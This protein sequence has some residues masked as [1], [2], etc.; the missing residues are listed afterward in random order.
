MEGFKS[1][2]KKKEADF[3]VKNCTTCNSCWEV[4]YL[5]P[6][7]STITKRYLMKYK[8]FPK[9]GKLKETCPSCLNSTSYKQ[10]VGGFIVE[11]IL[12]S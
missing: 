7:N 5:Q 1:P 3:V 9:Y 4:L 2:W 11:E 12:K 8:D 10:N 6:R